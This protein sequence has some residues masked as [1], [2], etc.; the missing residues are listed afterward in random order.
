MAPAKCPKRCCSAR[1]G[2]CRASATPRVT[3]NAHSPGLCKP[4][5]DGRDLIRLALEQRPQKRLFGRA[6]GPTSIAP[7]SEIDLSMGNILVFSPSQ[8]FRWNW[9]KDWV[10]G[11]K[12]AAPK[13]GLPKR[14]FFTL[15]SPKSPA[16]GRLLIKRGAD[17]SGTSSHH[18]SSNKEMLGGPGTGGGSG[19]ALA[20]TPLVGPEGP[21]S[22]PLSAFVGKK[23]RHLLILD[24]RCEKRDLVLE[25]K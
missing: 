15:F 8:K 22:L 19:K 9:F 20:R 17:T 5:R 12:T 18:V 14:G 7:R 10:L 1:A 4:Q 6:Q 16:C 25:G 24:A 2:C 23:K 3:P 11:P 21:N 13:P